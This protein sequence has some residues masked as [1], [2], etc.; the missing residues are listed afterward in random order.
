MLDILL[1]E[2]CKI[3]ILLELMELHSFCDICHINHQGFFAI[4]DQLLSLETTVKSLS[5]FILQLVDGL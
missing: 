1:Q 4:K 3:K 2:V 5:L